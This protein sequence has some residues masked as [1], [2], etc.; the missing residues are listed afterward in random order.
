MENTMLNRKT[1]DFLYWHAVSKM[2]MAEFDA[3]AKLFRLLQQAIP[4]RAD[5]VL[6][7]VYCLIRMGDLDAATELMHE[8]RRHPVRS[9]EMALLGRLHRRCDH[10]R[11]RNRKGKVAT[12][13]TDV[14][15]PHTLGDDSMARQVWGH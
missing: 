15:L 12:S 7:R 14:R 5:V 10:E 2:R 3:A 9:D 8:L 4:H 11:A 1:A 6:G 13:R